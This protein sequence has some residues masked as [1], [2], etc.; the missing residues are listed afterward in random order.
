MKIQPG[1]IKRVAFPPW[2]KK[3]TGLYPKKGG[4]A[5]VTDVLAYGERVKPKAST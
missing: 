2:K 1:A 5:I 3:I 4:K